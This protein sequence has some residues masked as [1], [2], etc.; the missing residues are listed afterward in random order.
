MFVFCRT[1]RSMSFV[2]CAST[3]TTSESSDGIPRHS[4][5]HRAAHTHIQPQDGRPKQTP[6][7]THTHT[8]DTS[9]NGFVAS[10]WSSS[11]SRNPRLTGTSQNETIQYYRATRLELHDIFCI[12]KA[13]FD[14]AE[15]IFGEGNRN[16]AYVME[17]SRGM[18][19]I[20]MRGNCNKKTNEKS[21]VEICIVGEESALFVLAV[22]MIE[23]VVACVIQKF[24]ICCNDLDIHMPTVIG[25]RRHDYSS[26]DLNGPFKFMRTLEKTI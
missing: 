25:Y 6:I 4:Q 7:H 15:E 2:N 14:I 11:Y 8:H 26:V 24:K 20:R 9:G 18:V 5:V 23:D 10:V 13:N 19:D 16:I 1:E 3:T 21:N 22:E 17:N 12:K